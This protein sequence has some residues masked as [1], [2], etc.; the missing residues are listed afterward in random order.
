MKKKLL[1]LGLG[2][3]LLFTACSG[4]KAAEDANQPDTKQEEETEKDNASLQEGKEEDPEK[5]EEKGPVEKPEE[6]EGEDVSKE[7]SQPPEVTFLDYSRNITD[8]GSGALLLAV[9]ENCPVVTI[10]ENEA[11]AEKINM[12]FEQKHTENQAYIEEDAETARGAYGELTEEGK[13]GWTGYGYGS[14]YKMV[15]ASTKILSIEAQNYKL[16]GTPQPN[17]W[18]SCYCFD[19]ATGKLLTLADI[20]TDKAKAGEIVKQ[21]IL[22]T[23]TADPYK[24]ALLEDYESFVPDILTEDVFYLNEKGLVVICNPNMVTLDVTGTIEILVPYEDLA[25]VMDEAYRMK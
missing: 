13:K 25:E 5:K 24:D 12:A 7:L 6:G 8:E 11:A 3:S 23:I 14:I 4:K 20:F 19:A 2:I 17:T 9:T 10:P 16:Q 22:D 18:T 1:L 15:Y 21:H